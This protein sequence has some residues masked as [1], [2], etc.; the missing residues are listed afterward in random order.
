[1]NSTVVN[2][3]NSPTSVSPTFSNSSFASSSSST[4]L[5]SSKAKQNKGRKLIKTED[6]SEEKPQLITTATLVFTTI[7]D[8]T[9]PSST[10]TNTIKP[11]LSP[12]NLSPSLSPNLSPNSNLDQHL[13][14]TLSSLLNNLNENS[15]TS[16]TNAATA[17]QLTNLLNNSSKVNGGNTINSAVCKL[18]Q[19][20]N[21]TVVSKQQKAPPAPTKRKQHVKRPM[22]AFMVCVLHESCLNHLNFKI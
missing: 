12:S 7:P 6:G 10:S 8:P 1:M 15:L 22:N 4:S 3:F 9:K 18:L 21:W 2:G 20:Y 13:D 17:N 11:T 19:S 14:N 5:D 16:S